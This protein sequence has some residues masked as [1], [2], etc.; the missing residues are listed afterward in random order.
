MVQQDLP[1]ASP[2]QEPAERALTWP[3]VGW[4]D[5]EMVV[6]PVVVRLDRQRTKRISLFLL[7]KERIAQGLQN[8][9]FWKKSHCLK[10]ASE[11]EGGSSKA[12]GS[13]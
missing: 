1:G 4:V 7:E 12:C 9:L 3:S 2:A 5:L 11:Q 10:I 13:L 8:A 6:V